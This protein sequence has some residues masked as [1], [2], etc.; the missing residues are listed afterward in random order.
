MTIKKMTIKK[1]TIQEMTIKKM[2]TKEND[3]TY[4]LIIGQIRKIKVSTYH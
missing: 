3:N 2:M 4:Q 1:M